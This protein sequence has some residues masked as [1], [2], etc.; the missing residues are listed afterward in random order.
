M[1]KYELSGVTWRQHFRPRVGYDR[2]VSSSE[3]A[4][5]FLVNSSTL[6][7]GLTSGRQ[8]WRSTRVSCSLRTLH[9]LGGHSSPSARWVLSGSERV[10]CC[11]LSVCIT[12]SAG[13]AGCRCSPGSWDFTMQ[14]PRA[15]QL[16]LEASGGS[17][18]RV[19]MGPRTSSFLSVLAA[20]IACI[21][22]KTAVWKI[23]IKCF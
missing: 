15:A 7:N 13:D 23:L 10:F 16:C 17:C 2:L 12:F 9:S 5:R 21:K 6:T 3:R 4:R 22:L 1:R 19:L 18:S 20:L 8:Q 11:F 14:E